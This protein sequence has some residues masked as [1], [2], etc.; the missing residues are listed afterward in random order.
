MTDEVPRSNSSGLLLGLIVG[1]VFGS[2]NLIVTWLDPLKEDTPGA[3][4]RFYGPMFLVWAFASFR[5]A[6]RSGRVSAGLTT[7]LSVAI[8]TFVAFDLLI[9]LRINLF[10][11]EL[12]GRDDWRYMMMRFRASDFDS[13][14]VFVNL[15]YVRGAPFKLGVSCAI[16]V[17]MGLIGGLVGRLTRRGFIAAA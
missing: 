8:A 5:A 7:G 1:V 17:L 6:R 15:D 16:G 2:V 3:L 12:T 11:D 14:R 9:L 4:L 10:L 13:L